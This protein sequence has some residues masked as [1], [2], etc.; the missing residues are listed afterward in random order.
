MTEQPWEKRGRWTIKPGAKKKHG[1]PTSTLIARVPASLKDQFGRH[2]KLRG[3]SLT[4][5]LTEAVKEWLERHR[6]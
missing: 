3:L 4:D 2:S 5:A 1:E 6:S